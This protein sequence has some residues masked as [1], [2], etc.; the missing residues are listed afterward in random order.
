MQL[1]LNLINKLSEKTHH[2]N[3]TE[4]M[5]RNQNR[6]QRNDL[7]DYFKRLN[8]HQE[9]ACR[10]SPQS[11]RTEKQIVFTKLFFQIRRLLSHLSANGE[12]CPSTTRS[13]LPS[14]HPTICRQRLRAVRSSSYAQP[15]LGP[16]LAFL[17][18]CTLL[19]QAT[20]SESTRWP[21]SKAP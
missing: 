15:T 20:N 8:T 3:A 1:R 6:I 5:L 11:R 10:A 13:R 19:R 17:R 21:L 18:Q 7:S 4:Q 9:P 12:H 14:P 2:T 16:R